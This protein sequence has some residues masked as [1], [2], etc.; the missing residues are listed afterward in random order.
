LR[1]LEWIIK[2]CE[3]EVDAVETPIGFVPKPEDINL[4]GLDGFDIETLKGILEVDKQKWAK[5]AEGVEEFY[6]KFGDKLPAA[7]REELATLKK[8]CE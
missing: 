2:R 3:N 8:N 5:E 6:T 1:V 4:E 7:L